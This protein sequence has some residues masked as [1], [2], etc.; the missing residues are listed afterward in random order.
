MP[1]IFTWLGR[2]VVPI[3]FFFVVEGF[4]CTRN[5]GRYLIRLFLGGNHVYRN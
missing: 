5:K 4:F 2:L 1:L 3:F